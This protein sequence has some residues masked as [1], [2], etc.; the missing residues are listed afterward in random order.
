M[1]LRARTHAARLSLRSSRFQFVPNLV[2]F[3]NYELND[4]DLFGAGGKSWAF[5]AMLRWNVFAG[6]KQ[7]GS[8]E[9][10]RATVLKAELAYEDQQRKNTMEIESVKR[11]IDQAQEQLTLAEM[12]V[13]Q[14]R[15]NLRIRSDRYAQGLEKTIDVLNAEVLLAN[16]QLTYLQRLYEHQV[17]VFHLEL[18][19]EKPLAN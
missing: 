18:L 12:A 10:A 8:I 11:G 15:E 13:Q 1:P 19:L 3:G 5:G 4:N 7:F 14:A 6:F 17:N 16:Q 9:S 2:V